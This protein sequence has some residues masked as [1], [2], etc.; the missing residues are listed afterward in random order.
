M[1][2]RRI[3]VYD[4]SAEDCGIAAEALRELYDRVGVKAAVKEFTDSE[5]FTLDFRDNHYDMAFVGIGAMIDFEAARAVLGLD[6]KCPLFLI[7]RTD[8]YA[9]EGIRI[10]A[11]DYIIKPVTVERLREAVSRAGH[12]AGHVV[13]GHCQSR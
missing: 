2:A 7:S 6:E 13:K 1:R 4:R 12:V 8:E 9:L 10:Q 5:A 3:S 11:L